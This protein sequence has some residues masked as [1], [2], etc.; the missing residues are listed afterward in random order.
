MINAALMWGIKRTAFKDGE[1][2][3]RNWDERPESATQT[4]DKMID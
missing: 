3:L 2:N 4:A 1:R